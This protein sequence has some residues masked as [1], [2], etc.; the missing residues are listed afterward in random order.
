MPSRSR[1]WSRVSC[2]GL[3]LACV[4]GLALATSFAAADEW[5]PTRAFRTFGKSS[6]RGLPQSSVVALAQSSDGVLWMGTLDGVA[7][8]D[9]RSIVSVLAEPGAP[10]HGVIST[11]V[12]RAKGGVYVASQAGV[13]VFD[14][15]VWRIIPTKHGVSSLAETH[16]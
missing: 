12:P 8:F 3:R 13:H 5:A 6:W 4:F 15:T 14:G 10:L 1:A 9:S 11:I 2:R 7:S 16:D